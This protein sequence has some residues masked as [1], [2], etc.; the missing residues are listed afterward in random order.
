MLER[1]ILKKRLAAMMWFE[2]VGIQIRNKSERFWKLL[3][4]ADLNTALQETTTETNETV[5][6][7]KT[8]LDGVKKQLG[9]QQKVITDM[10]RHKPD[11]QSRE[12]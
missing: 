7:L 6:E 8:Q 12:S 2:H 5:Q 10:Y 3:M 1:L 4:Q 11:W 9:D